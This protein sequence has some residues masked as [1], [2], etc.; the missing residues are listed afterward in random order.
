MTLSNVE[1]YLN[2]LGNYSV[3]CL[4]E[5]HC[6]L[7]VQQLWTTE[8]GGPIYSSYGTSQAKETPTS[9]NPKFNITVGRTVKDSDGGYVIMDLSI[10][11]TSFALVNVY[12][13]NRD[14]PEFFK[15]LFKEITNME[16]T[17]LIVLGDFNLILDPKLDRANSKIYHPQ[18][19]KTLLEFPEHFE[20]VDPWRVRNPLTKRYS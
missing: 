6:T 12:V 4:Q 11:E 18:A 19:R 1:T 14:D 16:N 7:D 9:I 15:Q 13:P 5:T 10:D 20:L 17:S 2:S 8:W 3:I